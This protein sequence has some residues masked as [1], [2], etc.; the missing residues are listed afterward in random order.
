MN[1]TPYI[2]NFYIGL[3]QPFTNIDID[4]KSVNNPNNT[5]L[6]VYNYLTQHLTA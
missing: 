1:F 3:E 4:H 6:S 5:D 2:N